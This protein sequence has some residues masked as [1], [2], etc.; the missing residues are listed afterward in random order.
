MVAQALLHG[1]NH[2]AQLATFLR[3]E[4]F[5]GLWIHDLILSK[6]MD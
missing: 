1:V 6:V 3:Q 4:G 2:R 5:E